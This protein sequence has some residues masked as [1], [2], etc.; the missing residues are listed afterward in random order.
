MRV[1]GIA[2]RPMCKL[3]VSFSSIRRI[4]RTERRKPR[5]L[6]KL[7]GNQVF[8]ARALTESSRRPVPP[9]KNASPHRSQA[10]NDIMPVEGSA[11]KRLVSRSF[12]I[13][14]VIHR[15]RVYRIY[16][17][18]MLRARMPGHRVQFTPGVLYDKLPDESHR[19]PSEKY[20]IIPF[21]VSHNFSAE[22]AFA[23]V[24]LSSSLP[25]SARTGS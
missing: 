3:T 9:P 14:A 7:P 1:Y 23:G 12:D 15:G 17:R 22:S 25:L 20:T 2:A 10:R 13:S 24:R 11:R 16:L 21:S 5:Y 19:P 8:H 4:G 18:A 6:V